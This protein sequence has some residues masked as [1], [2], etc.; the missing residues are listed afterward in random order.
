M[1]HKHRL[2]FSRQIPYV[3]CEAVCN[4][5]C[6]RLRLHPLGRSSAQRSPVAPD[7]YSP[8]GSC[9]QSHVRER[10]AD[11]SANHVLHLGH[12]IHALD[13]GANRER[14]QV[15][16][17]VL[18]LHSAKDAVV[19]ALERGPRT[20]RRWLCD[21][22]R[23][24]THQCC[25]SL[26]HES[27]PLA[28]HRISSLPC[29]PPSLLRAFRGGPPNIPASVAG[30]GLAMTMPPRSFAPDNRVLPAI[31]RPTTSFLES[32]VLRSC[33]P[34]HNSSVATIP[35]CVASPSLPPLAGTAVC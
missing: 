3:S 27:T 13:F 26:R 1:C 31:P 25:V 8:A 32:C 4:R 22:I 23:E 15:P 7:A 19:A 30:T 10:R 21:P 35:L 34:M 33:P 20:A 29:G 28:S 14:V 9:G 18:S 11:H 2:R 16:M 6:A 12:G 24:R 17:Q 5:T